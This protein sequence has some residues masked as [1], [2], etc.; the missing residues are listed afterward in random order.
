MVLPNQV[1][2]VPRN[3]SKAPRHV[4]IVIPASQV[5]TDA[6]GRVTIVIGALRHV[7]GAKID[8]E[9]FNLSPS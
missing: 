9:P 1:N 2:E 6:N 8:A 7:N 3:S 5:D 4:K